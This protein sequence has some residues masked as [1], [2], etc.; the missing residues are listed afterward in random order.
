M[1]ARDEALRRADSGGMTVRGPSRRDV[2]ATAAALVALALTGCGGDGATIATTTTP[3]KKG[4]EP[5]V[6]P[7]PTTVPA[8][9]VAKVGYAPE[10]IVHDPVTGLVAVG[11]REPN[12]L[13]VLEP[14]TLTVQRSVPVPG[15]IR[16]L[17]VTAGGGTVLVPNEADDTLLEVDLRTGGKRS[18]AVGHV[19]HDATGTLGGELLVGD[20]FGGSLTVLRDGRVVTT[21]DDLQHPG[22]VVAAGRTALVVDVGDYSLT[23]YDLDTMARV[24]RVPAGAGPTHGILA[25]PDRVA[26][27]DTRGGA[28]ILFS[29]EPLRQVAQLDVGTSPYGLAADPASRTVWVTLTATNEVLE[30]DVAGDAPR[31]AARWP[32]VRQPNTVAVDP[33]TRTLWIASRTDGVVQRISR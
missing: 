19:P 32:T 29:I 10:G 11:V 7:S 5:A 23:S 24:A 28:L 8:G 4:A 27:S 12:R 30:V 16:H 9:V 20:E 25:A 13:L 26:V 2:G 6:A 21:F 17:S 1:R 3:E 31:V 15:T 33:V 18:T 22:G 14:Q